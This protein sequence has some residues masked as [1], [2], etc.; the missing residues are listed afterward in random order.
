MDTANK[1]EW[2]VLNC[3]TPTDDKWIYTIKAST[4]EFTLELFRQLLNAYDAM[5]DNAKETADYLIAEA[6]R[7]GVP[8]HE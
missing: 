6:N 4:G 1:P 2:A 5:T 3:L 7:T 8:L